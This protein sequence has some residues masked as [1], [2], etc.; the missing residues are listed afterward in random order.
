[1]AVKAVSID[2]AVSLVKPGSKVFIG[3]YPEFS[4][5]PLRTLVLTV[6]NPFIF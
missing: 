4:P 2:E 5:E 3:T 1:M 6:L